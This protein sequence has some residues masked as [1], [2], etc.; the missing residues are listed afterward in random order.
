MQPATTT[1]VSTDQHRVTPFKAHGR[2]QLWR[3]DDV[4]VYEAQ[5]PFNREL[6]D[7]LAAA[8]G[9]FLRDQVFPARWASIA[10][11]LHS[12]LTSI[13]AMDRYRELMQMPRP[14]QYSPVATAFVVDPH[15]EGGSLMLPRVAAIYAAI[16]RP[17]RGFERIEEARAWVRDMID[18]KAAL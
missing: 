18:G 14:P 16:D 3:E 9:E 8:Q 13:E 4:L 10:V 17:F 15:V 6:F 1:V 5:G 2:V 7:A 11:I 12:G